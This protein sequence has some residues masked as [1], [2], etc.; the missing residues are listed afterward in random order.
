MSVTKAFFLQ[1][2]LLVS[3]VVLAGDSVPAE[4]SPEALAMVNL[5]EPTFS[6]DPPPLGPQAMTDLG[7]EQVYDN[8]DVF[9]TAR[10]GAKLHSDH[11]KHHGDI[12]VVLIHGSAGSSFTMNRMAGRLREAA[13]AEVYALN[14][15]GHGLSEGRP[16]DVD[17]I[18]QYA[19]DLDDV[20]NQIKEAK[21]ENAVIIAGHSMGGGVALEFARLHQSTSVDGYLL[22]APDLGPVSPTV[23]KEVPATKDGKEPALKLHMARIIGL[24]MLNQE[25]IHSYDHL[26]VLFYNLPEQM[27]IRQYSYRSV[28]SGSP[29]DYRAALKQMQQPLLVIVGE[30][31]EAFIA[32]EFPTAI[33]RLS[34]GEVVIVEDETH[35]G[36]RHS[37]KAMKA[38]ND[39]ARTNFGKSRIAHE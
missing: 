30:Q 2:S 1:F 22:F 9:F 23:R 28:L 33:E 4:G 18:G 38:V 6:S 27:P 8:F 10:D 11:Y 25:G 29:Q 35:N 12:T 31:D 39:W 36:I 37:I 13:R 24:H 21:P 16:G 3:S 32:R 20:L 7:F 19:D 14:L 34:D 17:Y 26:P 15:R 5:P